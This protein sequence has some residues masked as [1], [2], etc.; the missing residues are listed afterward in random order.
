[1]GNEQAKSGWKMQLSFLTELSH[2]GLRFQV[3]AFFKGDL[4]VIHP[5]KMLENV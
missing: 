5:S 3:T 1:M 4:L 2:V